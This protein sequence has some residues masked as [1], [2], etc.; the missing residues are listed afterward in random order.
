M[1]EQLRFFSTPQVAKLLGVSRQ[2]VLE[3]IEEGRVT[4]AHRGQGRGHANMIEESILFALFAGRAL[5]KQGLPLPQVAAAMTWI[6]TTGLHRLRK[7]FERKREHMVL[8]GTTPPRRLVTVE[9]RESTRKFAQSAVDMATL[10]A[11]INLRLAHE[12][13]CEQVQSL[14][15]EPAAA[16]ATLN[17]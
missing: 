11:S 1:Q 12:I 4:V 13:F 17:N 5:K 15:T 9:E 2:M 3:W 8:L 14:I 7:D 16:A 10:T 6:A